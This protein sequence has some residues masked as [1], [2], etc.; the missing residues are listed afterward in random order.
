MPAVSLAWITLWIM[1]GAQ[2]LIH[3]VSTSANIPSYKVPSKSVRPF[4]RLTR[5]T[6]QKLKH[7][8]YLF[9]RLERLKALIRSILNRWGIPMCV[10]MYIK[11]N[12]FHVIKIHTNSLLENRHQ[13]KNKLT[14]LQSRLQHWPL[15]NY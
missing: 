15:T 4:Q 6:R 11:Q 7:V 2:V 14:I 10:G 12:Y 8:F 5:T 13:I 9:L 1:K 3:T